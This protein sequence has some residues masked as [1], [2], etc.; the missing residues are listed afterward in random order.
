MAEGLMNGLHGDRF[1][2]RSAGTEPSV[3]NP[4]AVAVMKEIGIDIYSHRSESVETFLEQDFDYVITVCDQANE[5][6]P[7]F[8][9]GKTRIHRSFEDPSAIEGDEAL[10]LAGFR[11]TRDDIRVWLDKTFLNVN[12]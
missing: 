5:V 6:C 7:F 4:Y 1:T 11:R 10:K 12:D 2:A 3:V 9:G 8:P